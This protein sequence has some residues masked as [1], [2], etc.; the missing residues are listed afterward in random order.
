MPPLCHQ[1]NCACLLSNSMSHKLTIFQ[2]SLALV[3]LDMLSL[4]SN[5]TQIVV[6]C[7]IN[8]KNQMK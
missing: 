8:N 4:C 5:I 7:L 1:K 3:V 6:Q 2:Y